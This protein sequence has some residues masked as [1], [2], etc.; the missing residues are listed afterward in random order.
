MRSFVIFLFILFFQDNQFKPQYSSC[1]DAEKGKGLTRQ[2]SRSSPQGIKEYWKVNEAEVKQLE[3]H[4][5]MIS[6]LTSGCCI[7]GYKV[8]KFE[9]YLYQY[10]GV[11]IKGKRYIYINA[12][13]IYDGKPREE[14]DKWETDPII[15]CDGGPGYWG[16]LFCLEDNTF[17][18]L[19]VNGIA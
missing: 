19:S 16:V 9:N 10:I 2:C 12:A 17:K 15:V 3:D 13:R 18:D 7:E 4:F 8:T 14:Y 5:R 11:T 1:L 6:E